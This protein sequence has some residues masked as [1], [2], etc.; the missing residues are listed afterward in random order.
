MQHQD[1]IMSI[2]IVS[3]PAKE[4]PVAVAPSPAKDKAPEPAPELVLRVRVDY[5]TIDEVLKL[6]GQCL[7]QKNVFFSSLSCTGNSTLAV[8]KMKML[9]I[10]GV[11]EHD[12]LARYTYNLAPLGEDIRTIRYKASFVFFILFFVLFISGDAKPLAELGVVCYSTVFVVAPEDVRGAFWRLFC[13]FLLVLL[14]FICLLFCSA[15]DKAQAKAGPESEAIGEGQ[16]AEAHVPAA[17]QRVGHGHARRVQGR[18]AQS[19]GAALEN[20]SG[21]AT[22]RF[23]P[24]RGERGVWQRF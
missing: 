12:E 9:E 16:A 18:R 20:H 5:P 1:Y 11:I 23:G 15:S 21:N 10:V 14:L 2:S 24:G 17:G 19:D 8:L 3:E 7:Q 22:T 13:L 4:A 6:P